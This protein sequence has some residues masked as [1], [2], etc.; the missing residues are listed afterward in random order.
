MASSHLFL[1]DN[2]YSSVS[3]AGGD[4]TSIRAL[5]LIDGKTLVDL[6]NEGVLLVPPSVEETDYGSDSG[7]LV[8]LG[9]PYGETSPD[10]ITVTTG[11][12]MGFI[13][14]G[15]TEVSITS[16]FVKKGCND[17]FL[18]YMLSRIYRIS[19]VDYPHSF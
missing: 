17:Y 14:L 12:L 8:S 13:T 2:S 18:Q 16:R 11:N 6:E 3:D 15:D 4:E 10:R 19:L 9:I 7:P 1:Q 5:S